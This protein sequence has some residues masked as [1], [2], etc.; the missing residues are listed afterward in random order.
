MLHGGGVHVRRGNG[1]IVADGLWRVL[2]WHGRG[3]MPSVNLRRVR[4]IDDMQ[5]LQTCSLCSACSLYSCHSPSDIQ[6]LAFRNA[7]L[8]SGSLMRPFVHMFAMSPALELP[9]HR[10]AMLVPLRA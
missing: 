5:H 6:E 1:G 9:E 10:H 8:T 3:V 7:S 2:V 4:D